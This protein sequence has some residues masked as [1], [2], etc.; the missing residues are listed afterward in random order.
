MAN[1]ET[2]PVTSVNKLIKEVTT[3]QSIADAKISY[4]LADR[5]DVNSKL[6]NYF[7]SFN[8]P[9]DGSA[10]QSGTTQSPS[11]AMQ[12][13]EMYQLNVDKIVVIPI[14]RNYYSEYIDGRSITLKVPQWGGTYKTV[15]S[16]YYSDQTRVSKS[17]N[18]PIDYFGPNNVSF[19]FSDDVNK[20]FTGTTG[21]AGISHAT[22]TT[23]DPTGDYRDRPPSVEFRD[24][25]AN[26]I[27]SDGRPWSAV[28][29]AV[30][31][32]E[33]YPNTTGGYNYDIP[34]GFVCLDKGYIILTHP[35][36]INNIP[37]TSGSTSYIAGYDD[38]SAGE[39]IITG[40]N[41]GASSGTTNIVFTSTT[42][43][44]TFMDENI[45]A[46]TSVLCIAMPAK[47]FMSQNPTWPY[48]ANV[49]RRTAGQTNF[50][51]IFV[52]QVGLYNANGELIA[53]AKI[54]R[55]V[56]KNYS[57]IITFVCEIEI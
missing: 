25:R 13:P 1:I 31:V 48:Q 5:T 42:S 36:I 10:L 3:F 47:F 24:L 15:I 35:S 46:V 57:N 14:S 22:K 17:S 44:L 55:P 9:Y 56:E 51:S 53:V 26:D 7:S 50:D 8:I 45:K 32:G 19:L 38:T 54:D 43:T 29:Q 37:W 33:G 30:S 12:F 2:A 28:S 23:W 39:N 40:S 4:T 18:S 41:A 52:T 21:G 6:G 20:P 11:I 49:L 34:V 27:G 16:S